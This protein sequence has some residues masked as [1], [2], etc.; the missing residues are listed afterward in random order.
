MQ[1]TVSFIEV[2]VYLDRL[3]IPDLTAALVHFHFGHYYVTAA[4]LST[5]KTDVF[6]WG[7]ILRLNCLQFSL[8]SL[9]CPS[10]TPLV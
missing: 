10:L 9:S 3:G 7:I 2:A 6:V 4:Q 8:P 1:A 5:V